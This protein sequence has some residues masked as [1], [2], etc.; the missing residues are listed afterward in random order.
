MFETVA[1]VEKINKPVW[2]S[3]LLLVYRSLLVTGWGL[4]ALP[5]VILNAPMFIAC[6][7]ISRRKQRGR[8]NAS[9]RQSLM[10]GSVFPAE[11]LAASTVKV[12]ARDVVATWKILV[13][14][15]M[16][17]LVYTIYGCI[18]LWLAFKYQLRLRYKI[19]L[20]FFMAVALPSIGYS[21]LKFG[22]VGMDVYK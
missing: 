14:L 12:A 7:L 4:V 19:G 16:S 15:G 5:G 21:A 6:T 3:L 8:S 17:P 10:F 1:Q 18:A 13:S 11:A 2:R 20:P 9:L 22:E